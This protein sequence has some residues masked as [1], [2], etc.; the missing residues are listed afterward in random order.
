MASK[1][2][3]KKDIDQILSLVLSDCFFVMEQN[4][5]VDGEEILK[6]IQEVVQKHNE[7]RNKVNHPAIESDKKAI[8]QHFREITIELFE[9]TDNALE[10]LSAVVKKVA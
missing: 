6:I 3:L 10:K 4:K 7:L 1:K 8:K 9:V 2:R 5:K